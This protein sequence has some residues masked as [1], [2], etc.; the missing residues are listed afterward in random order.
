VHYPGFSNVPRPIFDGKLLY[1]CTGFGKPELWAIDPTGSGDVTGSHVR[2]IYKKQV[3][4]KPSPL[5]VGERLYMVSDNGVATCLDKTNG[6]EIW[7]ERLGGE[8]SASLLFAG[9][10]IFASS[11]EGHTRV[12]KPADEL[13]VLW[14]NKVESGIMASLAAF[15]KTLILRSK[16]AIYRIEQK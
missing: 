6:K 2:W 4:A 1:V 7:Q 10:H 14:T 15:D 9:G 5:L 12:F 3:P 11:H 13:K 8:Y 16:K